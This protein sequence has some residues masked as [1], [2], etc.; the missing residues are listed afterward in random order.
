MMRTSA[1]LLVLT[2]VMGG[3]SAPAQAAGGQGVLTLVTE[4]VEQ[5]QTDD[6]VESAT[7]Y[8]WSNPTQPAW[9]ETDTAL[10]DALEQAGVRVLRPADDVRIS[11]IYRRPDLSVDNA[12]ALASIVGANRVL[13]G[14]ITIDRTRDAPVWGMKA[15]GV[16]ADLK[17]IDTSGSEAAVLRQFQFERDFFRGEARTPLVDRA[18]EAVA[19]TTAELLNRTLVASSGPIGPIDPKEPGIALYGL[20]KASALET[21]RDRLME[22]E[23]VDD[24][25]VAWATDGVVVLEINPA[26]RDGD[27]LVRRAGRLLESTDIR[28]L[29]LRRRDSGPGGTIAWNVTVSSSFERPTGASRR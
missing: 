27:A 3:L 25:G 6:A 23:F 15:V 13:T 2:L 14:R 26:A 20:T 12:A 24:V 21:L 5:R 18:R 11:S 16:R 8:W 22:A 4:H 10:R 7:R 1:A 28:G 29:R 9:T 17:L 19:S